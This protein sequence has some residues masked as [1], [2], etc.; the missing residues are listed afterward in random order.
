MD[1][2]ARSGRVQC[3]EKRLQARLVIVAP[4]YGRERRAPRTAAEILDVRTV[5]IRILVLGERPL[6]GIMRALAFEGDAP[7]RGIMQQ[8]GPAHLRTSVQQQC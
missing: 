3:L 8:I 4:E 7:E 5:E 2:L 1:Q 6:G